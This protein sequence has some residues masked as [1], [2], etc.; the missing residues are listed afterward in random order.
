MSADNWMHCPKCA[1]EH[2]EYRAEQIKL[3]KTSYGVVGPDEYAAA[4][5][6]ANAIPEYLEE[7]TFRENYEIGMESDGS[8][9]VK[10]SGWCTACDYYHTFEH[11]G[12]V[13]I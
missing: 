2:T 13:P 9:V 1:Q 6:K 12:D 10:Y 8:F 7:P 11:T 5:E 4:M 3:A